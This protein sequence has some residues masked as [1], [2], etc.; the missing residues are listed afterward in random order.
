MKDPPEGGERGSH[1]AGTFLGAGRARGLGPGGKGLPELVGDA[2][3]TRR[4]VMHFGG[5]R[6]HLVQREWPHERDRA[7]D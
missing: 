5:Q 1:R 3:R 6:G 2:V 7:R 4:G